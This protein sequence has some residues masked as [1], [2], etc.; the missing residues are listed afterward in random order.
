MQMGSIVRNSFYWEVLVSVA[1]GFAR[2]SLICM[3]EC[4][5]NLHMT[6]LYNLYYDQ[7]NTRIGTSYIFKV[8]K[9]EC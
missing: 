9:R 2:L 8:G 1:I 3:Y 5:T 7:L 6:V 4:I